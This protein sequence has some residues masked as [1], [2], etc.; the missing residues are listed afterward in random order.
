MSFNISHLS[1]LPSA[2]K[3]LGAFDGGE[4]TCSAEEVPGVTI[5]IADLA[6]DG[7]VLTF[8]ISRSRLGGNKLKVGVFWR[9]IDLFDLN[10]DLKSRIIDLQHVNVG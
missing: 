6:N 3:N 10:H 8:D 2:A 5:S 9:M 7:E 4:I 1:G